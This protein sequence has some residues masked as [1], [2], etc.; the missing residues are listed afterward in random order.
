M[1]RFY[2][3]NIKGKFWVGIQDSNDP[4]NFDL[5]ETPQHNYIGCGCFCENKEI[6]YCDSCYSSFEEHKESIEEDGDYEGDLDKLD[7]L[8]EEYSN[9]SEW[10]ADK[11]DVEN[12]EKVLKEIDEKINVKEYIKS[13]T[14]DQKDDFAYQ[15]KKTSK[16]KKERGDILT[17]LA[18]WCLGMQIL[19]CIE[20]KGS[21]VFCGEF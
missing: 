17:L 6:K 9:E 19:K 12:I 15:F 4:E 16:F 18:R 5:E 10:K 21:C 8:I 14:F 3:G 11:D 2:Y 7:N 13:I 1:G 20:V